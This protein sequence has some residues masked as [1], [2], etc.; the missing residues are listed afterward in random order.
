MKEKKGTPLT[1]RIR[2]S[3][4]RLLEQAAAKADESMAQY[5]VKAVRER[6]E[7]EHG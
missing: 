4:K 7:R 1:M 2:P 6:A 5:V 3:D